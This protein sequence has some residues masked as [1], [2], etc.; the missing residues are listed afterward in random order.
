MTVTAENPTL[1]HVLIFVYRRLVEDGLLNPGQLLHFGSGG[2]LTA[3]VLADG[4]LVFN[5]SRGSIHKIAKEIHNGP[6]NGWKLW[7]YWDEASQQKQSI[8]HLREI[9]RKDSAHHI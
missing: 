5:G 6:A 2:E 3:K 4:D 9:I 7:Y 1:V 8:D